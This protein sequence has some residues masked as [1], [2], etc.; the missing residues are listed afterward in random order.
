MDKQL[1]K[2]KNAL[3]RLY[4]KYN[5]KEFIKPDPL[6]FVY[7]YSKKNDKEIVAFL[8]AALAYGKVEQIEKDIT[9]LL[10][11]FGDSP[12]EFVEN[13]N[14]QKKNCLK[15]FKH[16]FTTGDD[17]ADMLELLQRVLSEYGTIEKFFVCGYRPCD[18]NIIPALSKFC[19]GL[20]EIHE[21]KHKGSVN[22]GLAYLLADPAKGSVC[23]R[24][25][26]FL[27]WVVR[28]DEVD[29]GLWKKIDKA[30]LIVPV[31]VHMARLCRILGFYN[32]KTITLKT[33]L[34]ITEGFAEIEPDD[35]VKYDFA[36]SRVGIIEN[37][38]GKKR[39]KCLD[40]QLL[41]FCK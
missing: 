24:L 15:N 26:L 5:H 6:Q 28:A 12:H 18:K 23:K 14:R 9:K 40:C 22:K 11:L 34:K 21:K 10:S 4:K 38:T 19:S 37:C 41:E 3:D 25:N 31:D 35:P 13:F 36:L 33:A 2:I 17:I 1:L 20:L 7:R 16:R 29:T 27:R 30:K 39:A 32:S 8:S